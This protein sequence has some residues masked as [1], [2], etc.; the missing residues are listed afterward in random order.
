MIVLATFALVRAGVLSPASAFHHSKVTTTHIQ[1]CS[2]APLHVPAP[3]T[4][5]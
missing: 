2:V 5:Q 1:G 3:A 4:L